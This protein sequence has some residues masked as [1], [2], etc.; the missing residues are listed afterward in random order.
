MIRM[1]LFSKRNHQRNV[2]VMKKMKISIHRM[3]R[4]KMLILYLFDESMDFST[5][6]NIVQQE[7]LLELSIAI[8]I[9]ELSMK[10]A[11]Q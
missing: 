8:A 9:V 1:M 3:E 2:L 10:I 5:Y 6:L 11:D 4:I 7:F